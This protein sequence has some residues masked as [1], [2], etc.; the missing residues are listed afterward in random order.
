MVRFWIILAA[1]VAVSTAAGPAH[2]KV[3][4]RTFPVL[5][6]AGAHDVYPA[7]DGTVWFTVQ[8]AGKLGRLDSRTGKSDLIAL[9]PGAAPH[10]V[11]IGPTVLPGSPKADRTRSPGSI[12]Q[13][14][15]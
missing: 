8:S 7:A 9:G 2:A 5:A 11:I 3:A 4:M 6:G 15:R 14:A 13:P 10:G 12:P 1:V